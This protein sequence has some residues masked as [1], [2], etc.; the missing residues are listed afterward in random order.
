M[1]NWRWAAYQQNFGEAWWRMEAER[2]RQGRKPFYTAAAMKLEPVR[3][4]WTCIYGRRW[5][6]G[7]AGSFR[8]ADLRIPRYLRGKYL[9]KHRN[10]TYGR[11]V[12]A[13]WFR[14]DEHFRREGDQATLALSVPHRCGL[15]PEVS[16]TLDLRSFQMLTNMREDFGAIS[17]SLFWTFAP[18][19]IFFKVTM[20]T[21][22]LLFL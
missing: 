1:R 3:G 9:R 5:Q 12:S 13:V 6:Q 4:R 22:A 10:T 2:K 14:S 21:Y 19:K 15:L 16:G 20:F 7:T 8:L 18:T 17:E 11:E